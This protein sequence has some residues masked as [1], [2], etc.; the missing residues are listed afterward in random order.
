MIGLD[1]LQNALEHSPQQVLSPT[2][3]NV[4]VSQQR[5]RYRVIWDDLALGTWL[6]S[7]QRYIGFNAQVTQSQDK[8]QIQELI[9]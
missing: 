3:E 2:T 7:L 5:Y 1:F 6:V 4:F 8:L 9:S